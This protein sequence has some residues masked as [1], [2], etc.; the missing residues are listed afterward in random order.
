MSRLIL[1]DDA[2]RNSE[3]RLIGGSLRA[4]TREHPEA[5]AVLTYAATDAGHVG[6]VYQA[7]NAIDTG[8][9]GDPVFYIDQNG[10][11]WGTQLND[12]KVQ[13]AAQI[14]E[15]GWTRHVGSVKHRYV[16]ILGTKAERRQRLALLKLPSLPYPKGVAIRADHGAGHR[17]DQ[18]L[19]PPRHPFPSLRPLE[20]AIRILW[21]GNAPWDVS[22][23]ATETALFAPRLRDLGHEV[24]LVANYGLQGSS[25]EWQG[26]PVLPRGFDDHLNDIISAHVQ[27]VKPDLVIVLDDAWPHV[28][29]VWKPLPAAFWMPVDTA[30]I[31]GLGPANPLAIGD[32][33]FLR[34]SGSIPIAMSRHG[35][36]LLK[37]AGFTSTLYVPHAVDVQ[38]FAPRPDRDELRK[39]WKV[40]GRFVIGI[41]AANK[42]GVRKGL[43][44]QFAGFARFRKT[45][46]DALLL[47]HSMIKYPTSQLDLQ[48]LAAR[49]GIEEQRTVHRPVRA[50]ERADAP[51]AHGRVVQHPRRVL[52][53]RVRRGIRHPDHRSRSVRRPRGGD[54]LLGD[55]RAQGPRLVGAGAPVLESGA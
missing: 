45:H 12:C 46:D 50:G 4:I 16:Y 37:G 5:W 51:A 26:I 53:L 3:S 23:Y 29:E 42:D 20:A 38:T 49:L 54:G 35:E 41:A 31:D 11:R 44:E 27:Y 47:V 8:T 1:A 18:R 48:R 32:E 14:V 30:V 25:S 9:G 40:D 55:E 7:T 13:T 39:K 43:S 2:P 22:G 33:A 24:I 6:Y 52:Q 10:K 34:E 17:G 15:A 21:A 36:R 19:V 28:S